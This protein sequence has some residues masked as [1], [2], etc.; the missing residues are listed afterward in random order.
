M[1]LIIN[2]SDWDE[3]F[4]QAPVTCPH[5]LV[6]DD[7]EELSGVPDVLGRGYLRSME[8]LPGVSVAFSDCEYHQDVITK[9][10]AHEH[11]IQISVFPSGSLY[12]EQVHP[13]LGQGRS[14]FSGSGISPATAGMQRA[15]ER[16][17]YVDIEI[18]PELLRSVMSERQ[19]GDGMLQ[20][21]F[22]G[23]DWKVSFY[24]TVT[25]AIGAIARQ[26]W[27]VPYHGELKRMY[28]Q[29][30]V[31]ELLVIYLDWL[32][33]SQ[34]PAV[35]RLKRGTIAALHH[36][37]AILD[38]QLDQPPLLEDLV[39]Q[40]GVSERTLLRGFR[41][42]FG[43]TVVGYSMRQRLSRAEGLLRQGDRTVAEVARL[44]G[45]GHLGHFAAAF[46]RQFGITPGQC[47][48]GKK[49]DSGS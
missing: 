11:P 36:A 20:Q 29:A 14:Y 22:K 35:P 6:L 18:E 47:L 16:L 43:T 28:L 19:R 12:F 38:A 45:Y 13:D 1:T 25:P 39:R 8:L 17:T 30:K 9:L 46:K 34:Q 23:E 5:P 26:M 40:V 37:R 4:Q 27:E 42:L 33:D 15:G 7:F 31:M 21:L 48:A 49:A 24:P 10:P 41:Q 3:L 44:V 2:Q 32:A